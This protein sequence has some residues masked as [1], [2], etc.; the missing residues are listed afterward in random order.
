M[1]IEIERKFLVLGDAWK[2]QSV[3][4]ERLKQG[5]VAGSEACSVRVRIRENGAQLGLKGAVGGA[6]RLEFEYAIPLREA[7]EIFAKLCL[8]GRVEKLRH[9]VPV[10]EHCWEV[11]EFLGNNAG[12]VV[13]EIELSD[14]SEDFLRPDWIGAEVTEDIRYYN[15]T[16]ATRPWP[17]WPEQRALRGGNR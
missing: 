1:P 16:L 12:L 6:R 5:Y 8:G 4:S 3:S 17:T 14:E 10:G 13:A 2:D 15:T 9:R 7:E 11:D